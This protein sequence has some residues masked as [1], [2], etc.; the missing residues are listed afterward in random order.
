VFPV[1][2]VRLIG[3][4]QRRALM[5]QSLQ[6]VSLVGTLGV[7][8]RFLATGTG[9]Y[10]NLLW[11]GFLAW[12]PLV[13]ALVIYDR[14]RNGAPPRRLLLPAAAWLI[15]LPNAP[16]LVTDLK[17][18]REIGG[19]PLWYDVPLVA[20]F[21]SLGLVLGFLSLFLVHTVVRDVLGPARSWLVVG[22]LL[23]LASLGV[24]IGR[25][26]RWNSWD[27]ITDPGSLASDVVAPLAHPSAFRWSI[28]VAV[29]LAGFLAV[30]YAGAYAVFRRALHDDR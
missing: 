18:L 8:I 15:F 10:G 11:N 7:G 12:V 6:L 21:A 20:L 25:F 27:V 13:L 22:V 5:V 1:R 28:A 17:Y 14:H 19:M 30:S 29:V 4:D 24:L 3:G 16:Y 2:G 9:E 26:G 23:G